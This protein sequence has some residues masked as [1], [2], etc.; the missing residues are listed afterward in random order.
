MM[1][2]ALGEGW[3]LVLLRGIASAIIGILI[4]SSTRSR[5][6]T[7]ADMSGVCALVDGSL[8]LAAALVATRAGARWW[9]LS[10]AI[11]DAAA[12]FSFFYTD[13]ATALLAALVGVWA[14]ARGSC[15]LLAAGRLREYIENEPIL[16]AAAILSVTLGVALVGTGRIEFVALTFSVGAYATTI[17]LLFVALALKLHRYHRDR[18]AFAMRHEMKA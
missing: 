9:L 17:G 11:V 13:P 6:T 5:P 1:V 7:L 3:W 14:F 2:R 18:T 16:L 4:L 8:A 15:D 12:G 10:T